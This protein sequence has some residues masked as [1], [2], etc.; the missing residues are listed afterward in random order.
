MHH[1]L[2]LNSTKIPF[3]H[4]KYIVNVNKLHQ[5]NITSKQSIVTSCLSESND[6]TNVKSKNYLAELLAW[7]KANGWLHQYQEKFFYNSL[8]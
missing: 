4:K 7:S 3:D 5:T 8:Y 1:Q 2:Y 6:K